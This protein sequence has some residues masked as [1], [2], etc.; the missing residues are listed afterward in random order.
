MLKAIFNVMLYKDKELTKEGKMIG[1]GDTV[2]IIELKN[3]YAKVHS[4][5]YKDM[6]YVSIG[7]LDCG[8]ERI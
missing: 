1:F 8:F 3:N 2:E 4:K 6:F 5:T 7:Q